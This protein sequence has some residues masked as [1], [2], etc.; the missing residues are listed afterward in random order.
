MGLGFSVYCRV[1]GVDL[2]VQFS[3]CISVCMGVCVCVCV[4]VYLLACV[5]AGNICSSSQRI[6]EAYS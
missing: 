5:R 6:C 1:L 3:L 2:K 4:C